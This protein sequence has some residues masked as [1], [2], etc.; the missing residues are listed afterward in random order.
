MPRILVFGASGK[1][2]AE[3]VGAMQQA[4]L[5]RIV[6][7]SSLGAGDSHG[8]GSFLVRLIQRF[9]LKQVLIDKARQE[10]ILRASGLEWTLLRPPQLADAPTIRG[11]L[12]TC[13]GPVQPAQRLNCKVT[14]AS[15]A[16]YALDAFE[17]RR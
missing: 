5:R 13:S 17:Q 4:G 3:I 14:R 9:V 7:V 15:V 10:K 12:I 6:I 1:A 2:G 16:R 11:D 8:Q